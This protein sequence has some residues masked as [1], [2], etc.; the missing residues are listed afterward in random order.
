MARW[1][2]WAS[3]LAK[4]EPSLQGLDGILA[5]VFCHSKP[6]S[7]T[8]KLRNEGNDKK[9]KVSDNQVFVLGRLTG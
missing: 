9:E 6:I 5:K 8:H 1:A 2:R 3:I 7:N 4:P